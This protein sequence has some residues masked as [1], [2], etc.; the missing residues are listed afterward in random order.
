MITLDRW[1]TIPLREQLLHIGAAILRAAEME[2][3]SREHFLASLEEAIHLATLSRQDSQ[4][5]QYPDAMPHLLSRLNEYKQG[6]A[7]GVAVLW[8]AL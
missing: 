8:Q 2:T 3:K 5:Q 4:W 7:T 6:K 1:K